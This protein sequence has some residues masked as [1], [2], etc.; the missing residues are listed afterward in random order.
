MS[1][2]S[3]TSF[4]LAFI[5]SVR[6]FLSPFRI[7]SLINLNSW[8]F[9]ESLF[10]SNSESV[11][12]PFLSASPSASS[13]SSFSP[14]PCF[15]ASST[16]SPLPLTATASASFPAFAVVSS[17]SIFFRPVDVPGNKRLVGTGTVFARQRYGNVSA[18][19]KPPY[20]TTAVEVKEP[21]GR[22]GTTHLM[23]LIPLGRAFRRP[24][25]SCFVIF[26]ISDLVWIW[27]FLLALLTLLLPLSLSLLMSS[28]LMSSLSVAS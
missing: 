25:T 11:S 22:L 3:E 13:F 20:T 10:A 27:L 28:L 12:F 9:S 4:V 5:L 1:N 14:P 19:S 17:A 16:L 26:S 24:L 15:S 18:S 2:K 8:Q 23:G 21:M 6:T 7:S